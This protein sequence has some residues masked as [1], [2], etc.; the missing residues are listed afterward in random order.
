[1]GTPKYVY[2]TIEVARLIR[3]PVPSVIKRTE[4]FSSPP[5]W[6]NSLPCSNSTRN[7][8]NKALPKFHLASSSRNRVTWGQLLWE[9]I[10][11]PCLPMYILGTTLR[12]CVPVPVPVR[13]K[14][15]TSGARKALP[16]CIESNP[17]I[18]TVY[19]GYLSLCE[20]VYVRKVNSFSL[21]LTALPTALPFFSVLSFAPY[22]HTHTHTQIQS[23]VSGFVQSNSIDAQIFMCGKKGKRGRQPKKKKSEKRKERKML[24]SFS[25][26]Q[27]P[28]PS[29]QYTTSI[30]SPKNQPP[31]QSSTPTYLP[32][33]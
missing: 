19:G 32:P 9:Y 25:V 6:R 11:Y 18:Y 8:P 12:M 2:K 16:I 7:G 5:N 24:C 26:T 3:S 20:C 14:P 23:C 4:P 21:S 27:S 1:M 17:Y 22:T 29:C 28:S 13:W 15:I 33:P 10:S 31:W 30:Q